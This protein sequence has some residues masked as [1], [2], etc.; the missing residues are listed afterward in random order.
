MVKLLLVPILALTM[1][2]G[3][4]AYKPVKIAVDEVCE[5]SDVRKAVLAEEFDKATKPHKLRVHCYA[6]LQEKA[7]ITG[8]TN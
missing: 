8:D 5:S 4:I 1:L 6:D 2:S 7:K 3:C